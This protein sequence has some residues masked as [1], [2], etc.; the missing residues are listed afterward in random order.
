MKK[1]GKKSNFPNALLT[2]SLVFAVL[3]LTAFACNDESGG[4]GSDSTNYG[5]SRDAT[6]TTSVGKCSTEQEFK[7]ILVKKYS[8]YFN[9]SD[10]KFKDT[11]VEFHSFE[12]GE[13]FRF[14]N[15]YPIIDA[16]PAY[17]VTVSL[18]KR[19]YLSG[20]SNP[21]I[22]EYDIDGKFIFYTD[23]HGECVF[24]SSK[25]RSSESRRTPFNQ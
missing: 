24:D 1:T 14:Q 12:I 25:T 10:G 18:T 15:A 22:V 23:H 6:T 16:Y 5:D 13:A 20:A 2:L 19:D 8:E 21:S 7:N 9:E 17:P 3:L 4:G 11:E